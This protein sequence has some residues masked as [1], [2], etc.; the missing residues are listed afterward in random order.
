MARAAGP[1]C[2]R[3]EC[4]WQRRMITGRV[5]CRLHSYSHTHGNGSILFPLCIHSRN[6][7]PGTNSHRGGNFRFYYTGELQW[8]R[9]SP[10][11]TQHTLLRAVRTAAYAAITFLYGLQRDTL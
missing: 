3:S 8:R 1:R 9:A 6:S 7:Y 11:H 2:S 5:L 4:H 10:A